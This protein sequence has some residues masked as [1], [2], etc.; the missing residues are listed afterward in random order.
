[1]RLGMVGS[2]VTPAVVRHINAFAT[3]AQR[4]VPGIVVEV[5]WIGFWHDTEPPNMQLQKKER[6]LTEELLSTGCDVIAHQA[7]NGIPVTTLESAG[8]T[9]KAIGNNVEDACPEGSSTCL[10][11]TYWRWG[12]LYTQ[13]FH[14]LHKSRWPDG[15]LL[16]PAIQVSAS[17]SIVHFGLNVSVGTG[18]LAIEVSDLLEE[19]AGAGGESIPFA[20]PLCSTGQR[21][22]DGDGN[23]DCV[24][25]GEAVSDGEMR[26]MC[27][28]VQGIV[29]KEDP[30]N[31]A[32]IDVPALVPESGDC[33][34]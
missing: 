12:P 2:Y 16:N 8:G 1:M 29:E 3:G 26:G 28:F 22:P 6:V 9:A 14:E 21:D 24:A 13:L 31:P 10:G 11:A 30:A 15:Q 32:S 17:E 25:A 19:L 18:D 20:G 27:W 4:A 23:S 5:R 7:D 33:A 34:P